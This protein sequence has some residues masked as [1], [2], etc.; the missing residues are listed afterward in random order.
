MLRQDRHRH[1]VEKRDVRRGEPERDRVVVDHG[2]LLDVLEVRRVFRAVFRVHDR[3]DRELHVL[4]RERLA[5]VPAHVLLEVERV[6]AGFLVEIPAFCQRRDDRVVA[7]VAG[8]AV[9][10]QEVD[11]AVLVHGRVDA[12][13]VAAAVDERRRLLF[14]AGSGGRFACAFFPCAFAGSAFRA[15]AGCRAEQEREGEQRRQ[16]FFHIDSS[17]FLL[18]QA[19][20]PSRAKQKRHAVFPCGKAAYLRG[21]HNSEIG[22]RRGLH[23]TFKFAERFLPPGAASCSGLFYYREAGTACQYPAKWKRRRARH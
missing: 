12:R 11:L 2:D 9:E 19:S 13:V 3:F 16:K 10:Q 7:V 21:I 8:Q 17:S 1:V 5:V 22:D 15:A 14:R 20:A 18:Q 4:R 6:G 23:R